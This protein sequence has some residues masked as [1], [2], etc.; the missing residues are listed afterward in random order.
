MPRRES[1]KRRTTQTDSTP[2][3][4]AT[5]ETTPKAAQSPVASTTSRQVDLAE[6]RRLFMAAKRR[7]AIADHLPDELPTWPATFWVVEWQGEATLPAD[8]VIDGQQV[9]RETDWLYAGT[10]LLGEILSLTPPAVGQA[11]RR[12]L[13]CLM[14]AA[15]GAA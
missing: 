6:A 7:K 2:T 4:P 8:V 12:L 1:S 15:G 11:E 13:I 3:A 5:G 14:P 10:T 9:R